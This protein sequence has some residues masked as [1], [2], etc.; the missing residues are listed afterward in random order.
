MISK[1]YIKNC[2]NELTL[3]VVFR[4]LPLTAPWD[5]Y[6]FPS[7]RC[8][9]GSLTVLRI[10]MLFAVLCITL[11]QF[12]EAYCVLKDAAA[13]NGKFGVAQSSQR[14]KRVGH[15]LYGQRE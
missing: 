5:R 10:C 11:G 13:T 3:Y 2:T 6:H 7:S 4:G 1:N 8:I 14:A 12:A 9:K 15:T